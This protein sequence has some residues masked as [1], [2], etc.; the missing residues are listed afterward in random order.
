MPEKYAP[1]FGLSYG[2]DYGE[3]GWDVGYNATA[4]ILD[5]V[6]NAAVIS[7]TTTAAPGSPAAGDC[8]VVPAG[9]TGAFSGHDHKLGMYVE[10]TWEFVSMPDGAS[11]WVA[12]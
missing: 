1:R 10:G 5:M 4:K 12:E 3:D 2:W 8:Y 9:G 7:A 11:V 6:V